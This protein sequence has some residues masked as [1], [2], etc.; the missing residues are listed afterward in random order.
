MASFFEKGLAGAAKM[1]GQYLMATSLSDH[2]AKIQVARDKTLNDYSMAK[3]E[4]MQ[5]H[6]FDLE[7]Q[8]QTNRLLLEEKQEKNRKLHPNYLLAEDKLNKATVYNDLL[9]QYRAAPDAPSKTAIRKEMALAL[10]KPE[11]AGANFIS[12]G[13]GRF[14]DKNLAQ[15]LADTE[16]GDVMKA[17]FTAPQSQTTFSRWKLDRAAVNHM[18][19]F[20]QQGRL[21]KG[22]KE[23]PLSSY[24]ADMNRD[25]P[26][27]EQAMALLTDAEGEV[28]E[29]PATGKRVTTTETPAG[30]APATKGNNA[31]IQNLESRLAAIKAND[32]IGMYDDD[33]E[34]R[35]AAEK[36]YTRIQR[37][38]QS[39][40]GR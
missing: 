32:K 23:R 17:V 14:L 1:G 2:K 40:R 33:P 30:M 13:G 35:A 36:E 24:V 15:S 5:A 9:A 16:G 34:G 28:V 20:D 3:Q 8:A 4:D 39:L 19:Q 25:F 22:V 18:L 38:L 11:Q 31:Q 7:A 21:R 29:Q 26:S 10:G 6:Q 12:L 37:Q 27:M